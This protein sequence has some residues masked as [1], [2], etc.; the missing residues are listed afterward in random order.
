[1]EILQLHDPQ[2]SPVKI[3]QLP[4][5]TDDFMNLL[6]EIKAS[7]E[8]RILIDCS[9]ENV[10]NLLKQAVVVGLVAEYQVHFSTL[11]KKKYRAKSSNVCFI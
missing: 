9:P 2:G 10:L 8:K 1:M 7:M 6:K 4:P 3:R 11:D 5:D